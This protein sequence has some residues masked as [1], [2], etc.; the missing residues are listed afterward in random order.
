[1]PSA[2]AWDWRVGQPVQRAQGRA[3]R[4][5]DVGYILEECNTSIDHGFRFQKSTDGG[6]TFLASPVHVDKPG[7]FADNPDPGDL[8]PPTVFRAPN[9]LAFAINEHSGAIV[10]VYTN[11]LNQASFRAATSPTRSPGTTG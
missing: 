8:L 1:M 9:T 6:A 7:Q 3:G 2:A 10:F 5:P 4:H 11:Y